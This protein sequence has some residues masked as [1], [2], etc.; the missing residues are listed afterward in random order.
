MSE[1]DVSALLSVSGVQ[2]AGAPARPHATPHG[3]ALEVKQGLL[4]LP[5]WK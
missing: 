4:R 2:Q 1:H 3:P 5:L